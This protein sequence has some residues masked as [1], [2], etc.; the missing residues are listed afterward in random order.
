MS[1]VRR[2]ILLLACL[3]AC[4]LAGCEWSDR[5]ADAGGRQR[6]AGAVFNDE[7]GESILLLS[8]AQVAARFGPPA[9]TR[10]VG[11]ERCTFYAVVGRTARGWRFCFAADG[12]MT[13]ASGNQ[14]VPRP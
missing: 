4:L 8:A 2:P 12:R 11:G 9:T 14:P 13:G 5:G 3:L 1:V 7:I 10:V 6:P